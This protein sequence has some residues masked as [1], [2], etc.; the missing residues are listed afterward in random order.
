[1][2]QLSLPTSETIIREARLEDV[3]DITDLITQLGYPTS[4]TEMQERLQVILS[5]A[6][7]KKRECALLN[8]Y[9]RAMTF[10]KTCFSLV[11]CSSR[12]TP[13]VSRLTLHV[14][15]TA[16]L[17][18]AFAPLPVAAQSPD[19]NAEFF[20]K[21]SEPDQSLTIGDRITLRLEVTH[22][23]NSQVELPEVVEQWG[24]FEVLEQTEPEIVDNNDGTA[25][26][27]KDI[28]VTVF[29]PGEFQTPSLVVTHSRAD[30]ST[31]EL[32]TP[33]I[34][35][36][37]TSVLTDDTT[38]RDLKP[39]AELTPPPIWPWL[40]AGLLLTILLLGLLAGV[41]LWL[42]DRRRKRAQLELAPAPFIDT[43]PSEVIAYEELDR[44]EALNLVA[45][46]QIKEHYFLVDLCLRRYIEGRYDF[47][48]LEQTRS[49]VQ[50][51][52]RRTAAPV[53]HVAE[54]MSLFAESDLVKFARYIPQADNI[55]SLINR[56]RGIVAMTTPSKVV[57]EP[58]TSELEAVS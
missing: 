31:E 28:V 50:H 48:A 44:I 32:G 53:E 24:P 52:F 14:L 42:Y 10:L 11:I 51:S 38:L 21:S 49:E 57:V 25:T 7:M 29:E 22:P 30:G 36:N 20:L 15:L 4:P 33:V 58:V 3:A 18:F 46:N 26:T 6:D 17:L 16:L 45:H 40:V 2:K 54:F 8:N 27:S 19:A 34:Q 56:A 55:H 1:M 9:S 13:H 12:F 43:R 37:I 39:Q 47:P 5:H 23:L 41:A 35:L